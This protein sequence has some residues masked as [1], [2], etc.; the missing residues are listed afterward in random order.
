MNYKDKSE[1]SLE[2]NGQINQT[3]KWKDENKFRT[4]LIQKGEIKLMGWFIEQL[5]MMQEETEERK[6]ER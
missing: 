3:F 1:F 5:T 4:T 2:H 6:K